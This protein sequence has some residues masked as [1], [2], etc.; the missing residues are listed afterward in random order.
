VHVH[1]VGMAK[2]SIY[3]FPAKTFFREPISYTNWTEWSIIQ[4]V[5][6]RVI[7]KSPRDR[8]QFMTTSTSRIVRNE[9]PLL[10]NRIYNKFQN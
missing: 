1:D 10:I 5:I 4:E 9:F 2:V 3:R 6:T 7:S 8:F